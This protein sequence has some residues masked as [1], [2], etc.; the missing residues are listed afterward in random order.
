VFACWEGGEVKFQPAGWPV[1]EMYQAA[2]NS[3]S[4]D[5]NWI[6]R[7]PDSQQGRCARD[8]QLGNSQDDTYLPYI[9]SKTS[10]HSG[11]A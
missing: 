3:S 5:A 4:S 11:T 6:H 2:A 8:I 9:A 10:P 1:G 7:Y